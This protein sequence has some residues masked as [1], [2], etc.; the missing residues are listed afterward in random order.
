[1]ARARA[2]ARGGRRSEGPGAGP[3]E[4]PGAEPGC[5][6]GGGVRPPLGPD[7]AR[8]AA[9]GSLG[10]VTLPRRISVAGLVRG[11][12][13]DRMSRETRAQVTPPAAAGSRADWAEVPEALKEWVRET[14]GSPVASA[15][16][17]AGGFSP[18]VA[19]RLVCA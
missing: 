1:S 4:G 5:G 6:A 13:H 10:A 12:D 9:G 18:G 2:E 11:S 8:P 17:Q 3:G 14:L 15:H 7:L 19:A 16:S